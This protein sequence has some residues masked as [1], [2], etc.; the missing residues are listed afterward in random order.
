M[1]NSRSL[2][3]GGTSI[4]ILWSLSGI[5]SITK[6]NSTNLL[7]RDI[8]SL[9]NS[10]SESIIASESHFFSSSLREDMN[11]SSFLAS[12]CF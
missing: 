6:F 7:S 3:S 4:H 1:P 8:L 9:V 12:E 5:A 2:F 11:V 10:E